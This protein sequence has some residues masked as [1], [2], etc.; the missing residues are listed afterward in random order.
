[1]LHSRAAVTERVRRYR[2][3][4]VVAAVGALLLGGCTAASSQEP[5]APIPDATDNSAAL[6]YVLDPCALPNLTTV[7]P[8]AITFAATRVPAPPLFNTDDP[9][10]RDGFESD[11]AYALAEELGFRSGQV[12][13]EVVAP[14]QILSGEF[15]DYDVAIGSLTPNVDSA[16][17]FS[18]PYLEVDATVLA[19]TDESPAGAVELVLVS[20]VGNPLASCIDRALVDMSEAGTLVALRERWLDPAQL[21]EN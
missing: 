6:A 15:I 1:M 10:D 5:V 3:V 20:V 12:T 4:G 18:E 11:L 14:A 8:G 9:S 2:F 21:S 7:E 13:W 17:V 16:V 19:D